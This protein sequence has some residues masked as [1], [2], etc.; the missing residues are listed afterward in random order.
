MNH[1][2]LDELP[3]SDLQKYLFLIPP[4]VRQETLAD[5]RCV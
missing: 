3:E 1:R 5:L 4:T 2:R